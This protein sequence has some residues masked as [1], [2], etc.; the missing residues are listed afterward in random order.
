MGDGRN[1]IRLLHL[2]LDGHGRGH[3]ARYD[4]ARRKTGQKI[5][6]MCEAND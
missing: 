6:I 2:E 5:I 4:S 1:G 3:A